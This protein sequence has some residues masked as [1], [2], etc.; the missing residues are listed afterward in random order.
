MQIYLFRSGVVSYALNRSLL[1][2]KPPRDV[3]HR[4]GFTFFYMALEL[5]EFDAGKYRK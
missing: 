5:V 4:T 3:L 1:I 2:S